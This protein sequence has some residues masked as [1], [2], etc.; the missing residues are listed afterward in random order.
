MHGPLEKVAGIPNF[1]LGYKKEFKWS[2]KGRESKLNAN[3]WACETSEDK[4]HR[5]QMHRGEREGPTV[6][7]KWSGN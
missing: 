1:R 3:N 5:V 4:A 6:K 7:R 2:S